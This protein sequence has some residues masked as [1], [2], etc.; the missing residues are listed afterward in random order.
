MSLTIN[1]DKCL[2]LKEYTTEALND[3]KITNNQDV[4][5]RIQKSFEEGKN[6]CLFI[7]R[8]PSEMLPVEKEAI[9]VSL[10]NDLRTPEE[11]C[12]EKYHLILSC[13][14]QQEMV[15]IQHLFSK[16]I[17]DQSTWKFFNPG[18]IDR[19]VPLLKPVPDSMLV[20]ESAFQFVSPKNNITQWSFDHIRLQYP[21]SDDDQ[22]EQDKLKCLED[23]TKE[24]GGI[25]NLSSNLEYQKF[26]EDQDPEIVAIS[27]PEDLQA[28]FMDWL[29]TNRGIQEPVNKYIPLARQITQDYL[30]TLFDQVELKLGT[31]YPYPT[32][33]SHG[34]DN[35]FVA[36]GP[37][38]A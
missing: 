19:L 20:F 6:A 17:V 23:I 22:F 21:S 8:T 24:S 1:P 18:I 10:D 28:D 36:I 25:E 33:Y 34:R 30:S 2:E 15:S 31:P 13:N 38:K 32:N 5:Q 12:P 27:E 3:L 11:L 16:V 9:W 26:L 37:K 35:F 29:A 7:G 4:I 14:D